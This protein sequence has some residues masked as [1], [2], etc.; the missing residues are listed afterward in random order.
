MRGMMRS[1]VV[2]AVIVACP[3]KPIV[4]SRQMDFDVDAVSYQLKRRWSQPARRMRVYWPSERFSRQFG[5]W[6]GSDQLPCNHK[7][8]HDLLVTAVTVAYVTRLP[9]ADDSWQWTCEKKIQFDSNR[10]CWSKPIPD[11]LLFSNEI[12]LRPLKSV[13]SIPP[14]GFGTTLV[15]LSVQA[16]SGNFGR[17]EL[18]K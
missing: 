3:L 5:Q 7:I 10:G 15:A 16:G 6:T 13:A 9:T 4:T 1:V 2:D 8:G 14:N 11:A 12:W 18:V 17:K